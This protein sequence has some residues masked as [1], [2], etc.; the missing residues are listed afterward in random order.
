[1]PSSRR[2]FLKQ[3]SAASL[4]AALR[5]VTTASRSPDLVKPPRLHPGDTVGIIAP[6]GAVYRPV[7]VQ[8]ARE[9]MEALGMQVRVGEH[10]LD[11]RGYLAGTD[12]ARAADVNT[13]FAAPEVRGIL[14]LRGGWGC[15]RMLPYVDYEQARA[16]PKVVFG[17][18]DITALLLALY[19]K[20]GLVTFHGPTGVSTWNAFSLDYYR[21]LVIDAEPLTMR[22]P[23]RLDD[24][25]VQEDDRVLPITNGTAR[26][27]LAG[28]NLSVLSALVG[29][30]YLPGWEDHILFLE[31][32]GEAVYR[33][34][35][36]MTQL[37][38]AGVLD[39]LAGFVFGQCTD[40]EPDSGGYGSLT[41]GE[42]LADHVA[43]LGIPAWRGAMIG[44]LRDKFTVPL[45]IEA[46][47]DAE[48]GTIRL[49]EAA[50]A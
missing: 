20:S 9:R 37:R 27:R 24:E 49:L 4:V 28:G 22:N 30:P 15:A 21:R 40:C 19:A 45:G 13:M 25:L 32:I 14:C 33:I 10:V 31:D 16:N 44:H 42:V 35:R 8:I 23:T 5:P 7:T 50:V 1:M 26:G 47:I 6:A 2:R 43:P 36:M 34:D 17:Y 38:L 46:E 11:R 41:L 3:A 48:A 18:S 39:G 29:T 12:E